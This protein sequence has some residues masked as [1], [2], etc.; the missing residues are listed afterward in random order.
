[1]FQRLN[2]DN[3][4]DFTGGNALFNAI[5]E[6]R[7]PQHMADHYLAV[8]LPCAVHQGA[9]FF[10]VHGKRLF[11]QHIIPGVQQGHRGLY[12]YLVHGAVNDGVCQSAFGSQ[13]VRIFK[14]HILAESVKLAALFA[15]NGVRICHADNL[16]Q[17]RVGQR[18]F[19]V[20]HRAVPGT[21]DNGRYRLVIHRN[22]LAF[23]IIIAP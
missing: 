22:H 12:M 6:R 18:Q 20:H 11:Q 7:V 9:H 10:F 21:Y 15:P 17:L 13:C 8:V 5:V 14:T 23:F 2:I 4:T 1:M 19:A 16:Q 3:I